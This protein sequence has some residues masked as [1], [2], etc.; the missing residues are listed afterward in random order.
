[1]RV[2]HEQ[3]VHLLEPGVHGA[4]VPH[5]R[6]HREGHHLQPG[7]GLLRVHERGQHRQVLLPGDPS[8]PLL[9]GGVSA[10]LRDARGCAVPHPLRHRS[11][12]VL[13]HDSRRC[14]PPRVEEARSDPFEVL[15]G[16]HGREEQDV[17]VRLEHHHLRVRHPRD[18]QVQGEQVRVQWGAGCPRGPKTAG[19]GPR[20]RCLLPV[21]AVLLRGRRH[22]P[23]DG[24]QLRPGARPCRG[25]DDDGGGKGAADRD[26]PP[27]HRAPPAS[28]RRGHARD[29]RGLH[30][31]PPTLLLIYS[32]PG[33]GVKD[34]SYWMPNKIAKS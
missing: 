8:R 30:V 29:G 34:E 33:G 21:D 32:R 26:P 31:R 14:P 15:P 6:P 1:M 7:A 10:H 11:G 22:P 28:P 13:P 4:H 19:R 2:R 9:P 27:D 3:D 25:Q 24:R 18:D 23:D 16:A 5:R 17:R 12:P 20:S